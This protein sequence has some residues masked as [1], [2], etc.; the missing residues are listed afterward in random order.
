MSGSSGSVVAVPTGGAAFISMPGYFQPPSGITFMSLARAVS[1]AS[2][3]G[4]FTTF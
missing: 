3:I 2:G 1:G 4:S